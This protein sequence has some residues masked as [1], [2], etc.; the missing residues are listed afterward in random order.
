MRRKWRTHDLVDLFW[1]TERGHLPMNCITNSDMGSWDDYYSVP[2]E[3]WWPGGLPDTD[4][5][6][7]EFKI[8]E[9]IPAPNVWGNPQSGVTQDMV[10]TMIK[11]EPGQSFFVP[12][13]GDKDSARNLQQFFAYAKQVVKDKAIKHLFISR[14]QMVGEKEV[15]I[16]IWR[17]E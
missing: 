12:L 6:I 4:N 9:N 14:K 10:Q 13:R 11:M 3:T 8:E 2:I 15:G 1:A 5:T 16:R 17:M 7:M